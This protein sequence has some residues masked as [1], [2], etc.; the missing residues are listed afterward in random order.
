[1]NRFRPDWAAYRRSRLKR[2]RSRAKR[3]QPTEPG[4]GPRVPRRPLA[5]F[6]S[7]SFFGAFVDFGLAARVDAGVGA[8]VVVYATVPGCV[9]VA[10]CHG[11]GGPRGCGGGAISISRPS[12]MRRM[13]TGGTMWSAAFS[14]ARPLSR[15]TKFATLRKE[16]TPTRYGAR[17]ARAPVCTAALNQCRNADG[18][19]PGC[20]ITC[21]FASNTACTE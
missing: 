14:P 19:R 1:M 11:C 2:R 10:T 9:V 15:R 13:R 8:G 7:F 18:F 16:G 12:A 3:R 4:C 5:G 20:G 17:F 6:F 21:P